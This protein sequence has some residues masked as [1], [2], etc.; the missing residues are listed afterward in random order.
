MFKRW[1][2]SPIAVPFA[3]LTT[4]TLTIRSRAV[5]KTFQNPIWRIIGRIYVN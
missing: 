5:S 3:A 2:S 4:D 1:I